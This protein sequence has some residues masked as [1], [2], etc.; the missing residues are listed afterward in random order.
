MLPH[1][2][3]HAKKKQ[4]LQVEKRYHSLKLLWNWQ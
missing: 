3:G 1:W 4:H 2:S